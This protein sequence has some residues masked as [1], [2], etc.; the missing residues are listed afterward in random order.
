MFINTGWVK[1]IDLWKQLKAENVKAVKAAGYC[2][3]LETDLSYAN[4]LTSVFS[5]AI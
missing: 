4:L 1:N 5:S 3:G 2:F